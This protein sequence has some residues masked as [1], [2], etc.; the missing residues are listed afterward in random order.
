MFKTLT[1]LFTLTVLSAT[2]VA[3]SF[4]SSSNAYAQSVSSSS[5]SASSEVKDED[6]NVGVSNGYGEVKEYADSDVLSRVKENLDPENQSV[7][8]LEANYVYKFWRK[9]CVKWVWVPQ[10]LY[11]P[12]PPY[13]RVIWRKICVRWVYLPIFYPI[14]VL[15]PK[16][17][18]SCPIVKIPVKDIVVNPQDPILR[19][20]KVDKDL[21]QKPNLD[22]IKKELESGEMEF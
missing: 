12:Y 22:S 19:G 4:G 14:P 7:A 2:L 16:P 11:L 8:L 15:P 3:A 20:I 18:L 1:S 5:S 6:Y 21:L 10:Y 17:C 13:F 9:F